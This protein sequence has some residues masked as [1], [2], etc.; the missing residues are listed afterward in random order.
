MNTKY[1]QKDLNWDTYLPKTPKP[2]T[3]QGF[4]EFW[5]QYGR[6][7]RNL[8]FVFGITR[9]DVW[10]RVRR[11]QDNWCKFKICV[12]YLDMLLGSVSI[13]D[14]ALESHLDDSFEPTRKLVKDSIADLLA[15][16]GQRTHMSQAEIQTFVDLAK[17]KEVIFSKDIKNDIDTAEKKV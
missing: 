15:T 6:G 10:R 9:L 2:I 11:G 1:T 13:L 14:V 16:R 5:D 17:K 7:A 12:K 8:M 4:L 3:W